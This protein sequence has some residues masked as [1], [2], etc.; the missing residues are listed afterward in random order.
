ME[1]LLDN[2]L[3]GLLLPPQQVSYSWELLVALTVL[4]CLFLWAVRH[5]YQHRNTPI[6]IAKRKVILLKNKLE[7]RSIS[8]S[9]LVYSLLCI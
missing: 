5:W 9:K 2:Q 1:N 8:L 7:S 6:E 3:K 4:S